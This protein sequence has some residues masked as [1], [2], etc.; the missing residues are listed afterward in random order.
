MTHFLVACQET[1]KFSL[2]IR[3]IKRDEVFIS[4][5]IKTIKDFELDFKERYEILQKQFI[6]Q[7]KNNE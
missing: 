4:N 2:I 3:E 7:K 5:M 1:D 6:K